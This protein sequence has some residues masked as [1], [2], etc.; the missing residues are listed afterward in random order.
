[1]LMPNHLLGSALAIKNLGKAEESKSRNADI[2]KCH[3]KI[4]KCV[5]DDTLHLLFELP[6]D[7]EQAVYEPD[8]F[9]IL[10]LLLYPQLLKQLLTTIAK[11]QFT[12]NLKK[13]WY[14]GYQSQNWKNILQHDLFDTPIESLSYDWVVSAN[15]KAVLD[16]E[17][18]IDSLVHET[19][20]KIFDIIVA[21]SGPV[22]AEDETLLWLKEIIGH[23]LNRLDSG[24]VVDRDVLVAQ[25]HGGAVE[26]H[27]AWSRYRMTLKTADFMDD[28]TIVAPEELMGGMQPQQPV[29]VIGGG[30]DPEMEQA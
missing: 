17:D 20:T 23:T 18:K 29:G 14:H 28:L 8:M 15:E 9:V 13:S 24:D 6:E 1:M 30:Q 12:H 21:R 10:T 4:N 27:F 5:E 3:E 19:V 25:L 26:T 7:P 11:K 22:Y 2:E 16:D